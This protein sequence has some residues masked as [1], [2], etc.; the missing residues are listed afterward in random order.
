VV[1]GSLSSTNPRF[2]LAGHG[3]EIHRVN[4]TSHAQPDWSPAQAANPVAPSKV[5]GGLLSLGISWHHAQ[6]LPHMLYI[7]RYGDNSPLEGGGLRRVGEA[8]PSPTR[9]W[10]GVRFSSIR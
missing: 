9:S 8:E 4:H 2:R 6:P 10:V 1:W 7:L 5:A 3:R